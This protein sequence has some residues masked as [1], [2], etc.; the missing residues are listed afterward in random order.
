MFELAPPAPLGLDLG[1]GATAA[2]LI[3][4]A[5]LEG[6]TEPT[7]SAYAVS[8]RRWGERCSADGVDPLGVD[9]VHVERWLRELE[10]AGTQPATR[11]RHLA[12]LSGFYA[13]ACERGALARSPVRRVRRPSVSRD[14]PRLGLDR[15]QARALVDTAEDAG[16][17]EHALICLL[18]LN[19][20][21]VSEAVCL[22][23]GDLCQ[24][25]GHTVVT[26]TRKGGARQLVPLAPRTA[27]ALRT[28][29]DGHDGTVELFEDDG[30]DPLDRFDALR[31]V[32]RLGR[33]AGIPFPIS[34]HT[35]RHTFVTL[36][37]D[38]GVS[39]RDVQDAAGHADP[40]TTRRYDRGRHSLDR[41][42]TYA[43]ARH[44]A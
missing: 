1:P 32:R 36:S 34:P 5:F 27:A 24:V 44:L 9:R 14:S 41:H 26:V 20:L 37:L 2:E 30:G 10:A 39:L 21:R 4:A 35:L 8:L 12:A 33:A 25:R 43:L 29:A 19:G 18:L 15:D 16:V 17:R 40:R 31:I 11:A 6:Y 3:A 38:A 28:L 7:R 13:E 23:V 22:A 42:A